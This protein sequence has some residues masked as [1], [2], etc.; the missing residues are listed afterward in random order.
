MQLVYPIRPAP[1]TAVLV[2][3]FR[4]RGPVRTFPEGWTQEA[5]RF[6]PQ[7][8]AGTL[9]QLDELARARPGSLTHAIIVLEREGDP[10][11]AEADRERLWR[12]FHVP[13]FEQVIAEDGTLLGAECEAH[14]GLHIES[15]QWWLGGQ[16]VDASPCGCGRKTPRVISTER[17]EFVR[18]VAAYAR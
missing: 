12:A 17:V 7:A 16:E 2:S 14:N 8:I 13:V 1:R 11:L 10:R 3:G 9:A 15:T 18:G 5:E 4:S 6:A